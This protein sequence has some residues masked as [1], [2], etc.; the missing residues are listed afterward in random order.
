LGKY[1]FGV[2]SAASPLKEPAHGN[3]STCVLAG[4]R[5]FCLKIES[6]EKG[7][8]NRVSGEKKGMVL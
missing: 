3:N 6:R 4:A 2:G 1:Y 7:E 8:I 5:G